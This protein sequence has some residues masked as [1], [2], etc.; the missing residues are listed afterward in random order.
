MVREFSSGG[1]VVRRMRGR[2]WIAAIE[3]QRHDEK[4]L[5]ILALPKGVIDH[6][7]SAAQT[8]VREVHEETG[9]RGEVVTKLDDIK[10]FFVRS[11]GDRQRVFKVVSFFLLRYLSGHI[12]DVSHEMREEVKRA[13]WIPLDTAPNQLSYRGER[14]MAARAQQYLAQHPELEKNPHAS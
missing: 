10:Y 8:A 3:P 9:V 11:W 14:D 5:G 1:V 13:L 7:E 12:D 4:D 2:W 6:G